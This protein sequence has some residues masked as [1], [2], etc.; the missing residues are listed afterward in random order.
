MAIL[1]KQNNQELLTLGVKLKARKTYR[2]SA[3]VQSK[4]NL[5][6]RA[7]VLWNEWCDVCC[8]EIRMKLMSIGSTLAKSDNATVVRRLGK[9]RPHALNSIHKSWNYKIIDLN[10]MDWAN[11]SKIHTRPSAKRYFPHWWVR[12]SPPGMTSYRCQHSVM[13]MCQVPVSWVLNIN[14]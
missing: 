13:E 12:A 1:Q 14:A 7:Y 9:R 8:N 4:L 6:C 5:I 10:V 3:N 2:P 11:V